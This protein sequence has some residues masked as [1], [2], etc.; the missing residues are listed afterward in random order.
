[1]KTMR[2][3]QL[4]WAVLSFTLASRLFAEPVVQVR[5]TP[6]MLPKEELWFLLTQKGKE[7]NPSFLEA[8]RKR[9]ETL[10]KEQGFWHSKVEVSKKRTDKGYVVVFHLKPGPLVQVER[11]EL[12]G[13]EKKW[14]KK[15]L[16]AFKRYTYPW[17]HPF[18]WL[19]VRP[20]LLTPKGLA[21][22]KRQLKQLLYR[23]GYWEGQVISVRLSFRT[24]SSVVCHFVVKRG[25]RYRFGRVS[26]PLAH[27]SGQPFSLDKVEE[28]LKKWTAEQ[29][30][31]G[32]LNARGS[33]R[34]DRVVQR[35]V[36]LS[37]VLE[38]GKPYFLRR[39]KFYGHKT[40]EFLLRTVIALFPG[41]RL[42]QSKLVKAKEQLLATSLFQKVR[43]QLSSPPPPDSD[44]HVFLEEK[45]GGRIFLST[46]YSSDFGPFVQAKLEIW[47]FDLFRWKAFPLYGGGQKLHLQGVFGEDWRSLRFLWADPYFLWLPL[48]FGV[49]ASYTFFRDFPYR[50]ERRGGKL[51]WLRRFSLFHMR[52]GVEWERTKFLGQKG[53]DFLKPL[54]KGLELVSFHLGGGIE[55]KEGGVLFQ[56]R[57]EGELGHR[58]F[59]SEV[60]FYKWEVEGKIEG[61]PLP[62][63]SFRSLGGLGKGETFSGEGLPY[64]RRFF[65]GGSETLR[66]FAYRRVGRRVAGYPLGGSF[67]WRLRLEGEGKTLSWLGITLFSDLGDIGEKER[68]L[69]HGRLRLSLG[70]GFRFYFLSSS[71]PLA[72]DFAWPLF[73]QKEDKRQVVSLSLGF[74]I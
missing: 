50:E 61:K 40:H 42:T 28:F 20:Y 7:L 44:L 57:F 10:L 2:R 43:F 3:T 33:Y 14:R 65:L 66:G 21:K 31:K 52:L 73:L 56:V 74:W 62:W 35:R 25:P 38:K 70:F 41:E 72:V 29:R 4:W 60:D 59:G 11:V 49:E 13:G 9:L 63:L 67:Y 48:T 53:V 51:W 30:E 34:I 22:A 36:H 1:M 55:G 64:P 45:N 8:D 23:K 58:R 5:L 16:S 12:K 46:G 18:R 69:S 24:K 37:L 32:F 27:L 26:P 54:E 15:L 6:P 19:G 68:I 71:L 39:L 47:N 17:Y